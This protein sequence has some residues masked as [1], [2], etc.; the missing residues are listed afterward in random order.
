[1]E[2]R[3]LLQLSEVQLIAVSHWGVHLVRREQNHLQVIRSFALGEIGSCAAPRPTSV[4][5]DSP[6]GRLSLHT[7]RAQQLSEM[8]TKFC[9]EQRKVSLI[10]INSKEVIKR[11]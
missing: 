9:A 8:V 1:M 3:L 5:L 7:P 4:S 6:Q 10:R 2:S 11:N